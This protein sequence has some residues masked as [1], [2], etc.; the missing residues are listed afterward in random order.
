M[1]AIDINTALGSSI[2][3]FIL[4]VLIGISLG[5]IIWADRENRKRD[6]DESE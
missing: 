3:A 2:M 4:G 1:L 5:Y 6:N